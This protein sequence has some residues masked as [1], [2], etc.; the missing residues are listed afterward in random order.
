MVTVEKAAT[1]LLPI[2]GLLLVAQL[3]LCKILAS[4]TLRLVAA[5]NR[6]NN[7]VGHSLR[8]RPIARQTHVSFIRM[9]FSL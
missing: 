9:C 3:T 5:L 1:S 7:I 4:V 2:Y 6:L 8:P